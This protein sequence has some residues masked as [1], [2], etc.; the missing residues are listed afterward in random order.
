M[1]RILS[2]AG[3]VL[4][5]LTATGAY[6]VLGRGAPQGPAQPIEFYHSVHAG[7]NQIPC[8]YC[9]YT[10]DRSNSAGLPSVGTCVGCHVPGGQVTPPE[11]AQAMFPTVERDSMWAAEIDKMVGYWRR[12]EAIPWVRVYNLPQHVQFPHSM[13]IQAGLECSTC[14]GPVEEME[15]V[16]QY[17]S[18]QMGW[19]VQ[20]HTGQTPLSEEEERLVRER[21]MYVRRISALAEAGSSIAG[22]QARWPNQRASIDCVVCHY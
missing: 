16:Y 12:G 13:H 11:Q 7:Q 19:C 3:V 6:L 1:I 15:R 8:M 21:S 5:A 22:Q 14:H 2:L 17:S 9:H 10:A 18:L 4:L 20:C